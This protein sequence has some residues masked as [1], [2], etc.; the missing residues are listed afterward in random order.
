MLPVLR[1]LKLFRIESRY[2]VYTTNH[3]CKSRDNSK[4]F[5]YYYLPLDPLC[6]LLT[7]K[8]Q[9][10]YSVLYPAIA[11]IIVSTQGVNTHFRDIVADFVL[12]T[13]L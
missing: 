9:A 5:F 8:L 4:Y 6:A 2:H 7:I 3:T 11:Y 1:S 10:N 12:V 13:Q